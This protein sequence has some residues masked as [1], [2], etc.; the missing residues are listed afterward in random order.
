MS[1][2]LKLTYNEDMFPVKNNRKLVNAAKL[3]VKEIDYHFKKDGWDLDLNFQVDE[4]FYKAYG[5]YLENYLIKELFSD[6][7]KG[8][9]ITYS[10]KSSGCV[11]KRKKV[12][13]A[14]NVKQSKKK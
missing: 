4:V 7:K 8:Y 9:Y 3:T 12:K 14:K 10:N 11:I 2:T 5:E 6:P 1:K 13:G